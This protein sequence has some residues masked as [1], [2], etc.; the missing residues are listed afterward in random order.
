MRILLVFFMLLNAANAQKLVAFGDSLTAGFGL[1]ENESFPNLLSKRLNMPV[2]N[3]GV[4]GDTTAQGLARL[5]WSLPQDTKGVILELG[6]NDALRGLPVADAKA[7]LEAMIKILQSKDIKI[8]LTGMIAPNNYGED[9]KQK[10]NAIYPELAA[11]YGLKLYPFFLE[12]VAG[13]PALNQRD[14]IHPTKEG[15]EIIVENILPMVKEFVTS[16]K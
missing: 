9:Y 6:A 16:I 1:Q 14:R 10:F 7:N 11:K 5:E 13:N 2:L 12:G 15:V 3:A 4:S 8:L